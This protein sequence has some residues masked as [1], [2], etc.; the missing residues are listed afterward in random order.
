M[1]DINNP[2]GG[3]VAKTAQVIAS[4]ESGSNNNTDTITM[5]GTNNP[6]G[7]DNGQKD[8]VC[9]SSQILYLFLMAANSTVT[10]AK[11]EETWWTV[12]G[13]QTPAAITSSGRCQKTQQESHKHA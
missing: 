6:N 4:M 7:E 9:I 2:A 10:S 1:S 3:N 12:P 11:M 8:Q 13:V 5:S